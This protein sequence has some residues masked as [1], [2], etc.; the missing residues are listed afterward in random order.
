VTFSV[1]NIIE[2]CREEKPLFLQTLHGFTHEIKGL[3][4]SEMLLFC[5]MSKHLGAAHVL[6]SGR[7]RGNSTE[8]LARFFAPTPGV[9]VF[10]VENLKYTED[11]VIA[12]RRLYKRHANLSLLYGDSFAVLPDLCSR[13]VPCTVLIDG[14]KGKYALQLASVLLAEEQV[15]AVFI[16]DSHKDTEHRPAIE[17]LYPETFSSD[18]PAFVGAFG[19][20]D[21]PCWDLYRN[22][23]GY[24]DWGP[25]QRGPRRMQSY[26]PTLTMILNAPDRIDRQREVRDLFA[27]N[28]IPPRHGPLGRWLRTLRRSLPNASEWPYFLQ[29]W[30]LFLRRQL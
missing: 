5:A 21:E 28:P 19:S 29:Y 25:Y 12:T 15:K 26:G 27:L 13:R 20:L 8:I 18:D 1:Q 3:M 2:I 6:E 23:E 16:H 11:S 24:Q 4:N 30:G 9:R 17:S 14:P 22:W 7:A 10:S